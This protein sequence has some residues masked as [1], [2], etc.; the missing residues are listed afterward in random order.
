MGGGEDSYGPGVLR[1]LL[2]G[3]RWLRDGE[4]CEVRMTLRTYSFD[5]LQAQP[6]LQALNAEVHPDLIIG[7][8]LGCGHA[9][10]LGGAPHLFLSPGINAFRTLYLLSFPARMKWFREWALRVLIHDKGGRRQQVSFDPELLARY[11]GLRDLAIETFRRNNPD[12]RPLALIGRQDHFRI[13]GVGVSAFRWKRLFG[14]DS[15][16]WFSLDREAGHTNGHTLSERQEKSLLLEAVKA[17]LRLDSVTWD[18]VTE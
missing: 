15:V 14:K 3:G 4:P 17:S 1:S 18:E 13:L 2:E 7:E 10:M 12:E 6:F 11:R 9:M 8:S 16:R 5:P